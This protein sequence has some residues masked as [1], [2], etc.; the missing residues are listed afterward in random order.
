MSQR[1][2]RVY[3]RH[4]LDHA[5]DAAEIIQGRTRQDLET[6][7]TLRY[8]LL[9]IVCITGEAAARVSAGTQQQ[10]A[11]IPWKPII[12][13]RNRLIHGY[14]TVDVKVLWDTVQDDFPALTRSLETA[15]RQMEHPSF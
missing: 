4:M 13:M 2:D 14:D 6:D 9:H 12:G 5:R 11:A 15:L 3:L 8:A 10:Y 1:D 7:R